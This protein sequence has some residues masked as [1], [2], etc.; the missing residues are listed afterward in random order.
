MSPRYRDFIA[1]ARQN[2]VAGIL[3]DTD[4]DCRKM[5][6]VFLETGVDALMPFE[7][8]AGMDVAQLRPEF[9]TLGI[10][11]GIDKRALVGTRDDIRREVDRVLARFGRDGGF[12]PTLDHTVPPNVSLANFQFYLECV[13][14]YEG[15]A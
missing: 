9:P 5:I 8:Q 2:G 3:V 4:G 15:K 11:G 13:R 7:V 14:E 6:P 1:T 12:I 10:M